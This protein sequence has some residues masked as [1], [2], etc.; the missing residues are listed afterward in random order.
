VASSFLSLALTSGEEDNTVLSLGRSISEM[1]SRAILLRT[2]Q[3]GG[4]GVVNLGVM[5]NLFLGENNPNIVNIFR[6]LVV[7]KVDVAKTG[8]RFSA[9][10]IIQATMMHKAIEAEGIYSHHSQ[11]ILVSQRRPLQFPPHNY[12]QKNDFLYQGIQTKS[13]QTE[14]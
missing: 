7:A 5:C 3:H 11:E 2:R 13:N 14:R 6:H 10:N 9:Q 8:K 4:Y 1:D 12:S